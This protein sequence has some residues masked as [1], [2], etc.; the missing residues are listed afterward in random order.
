MIYI[1]DT[2]QFVLHI[3]GLVVKARKWVYD[4]AAIQ[5]NG[6]DVIFF[7]AIGGNIASFSIF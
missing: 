7:V 4:Q 3:K 1:N 5:L 6:P 2:K